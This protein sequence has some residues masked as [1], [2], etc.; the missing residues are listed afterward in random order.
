M[1]RAF[2][3]VEAKITLLQLRK[4]GEGLKIYFEADNQLILSQLSIECEEAPGSWPEQPESLAEPNYELIPIGRVS[5]SEI[6]LL[7]MPEEKEDIWL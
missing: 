7:S 6:N 3:K 4:T 5:E 2:K 1:L